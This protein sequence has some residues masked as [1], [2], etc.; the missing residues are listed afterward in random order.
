VKPTPID[1]SGP[2]NPGRA[3]PLRST[4]WPSITIAT[5]MKLSESPA[6]IWPRL[7]FYEQIDIPPPFYLRLLLPLPI[8]SEGAKSAVGDI[9]T[10]VYKGGHLLKRVVRTEPGQHYEF[11]VIEQR[12]AFGGGLQL[13]GGTYHFNEYAPGHTELTITTRYLSHQRPRILWSRI[14]KTVCH[15]FHRHLLAAIRGNVPRR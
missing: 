12:L 6:Q 4:V 7:M 13:L 15:L 3:A 9:A 10:C 14:E 11:E 5:R 2:L 8:R 1:N